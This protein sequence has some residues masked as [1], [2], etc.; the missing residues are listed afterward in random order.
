MLQANHWITTNH[1]K[2]NWNSVTRCN[3]K[4]SVLF[5]AK[6]SVVFLEIASRSIV[7][8][9]DLFAFHHQPPLPSSSSSWKRM[10]GES[11]V[12][13]MVDCA[14]TLFVTSV[15]WDGMRV[16]VGLTVGWGKIHKRIGRLSFQNTFIDEMPSQLNLFSQTCVKIKTTNFFLSFF[17]FQLIFFYS[18]FFLICFFISFNFYTKSFILSFSEFYLDLMP[19]AFG[20]VFGG[21]MAVSDLITSPPHAFG[22]YGSS[23]QAPSSRKTS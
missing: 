10:C 9:D 22:P 18:D 11:S 23:S 16:C 6:I 21:E 17:E 5:F 19:V 12:G 4:F 7:S 13:D 20:M 2:L 14:P 1:H 15:W 8:V 3:E